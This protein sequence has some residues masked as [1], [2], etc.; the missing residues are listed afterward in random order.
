VQAAALAVGFLLVSLYGGILSDL[1][2]QLF[3][4]FL[5]VSDGRLLTLAL[6]ACAVL[7]LLAVLARPLLLVS[8]DPELAASRGLRV[9]LISAAFL[10][11]LALAVAA[12]SQITGVLLVFALLVG[13]P[14]SAQ[15]LTARPAAGLALSVVLGVLVA[16]I[17]LGLSYFSSYPAGF[18][19][20]TTSTVL[21]LTARAAG[22]LWPRLRP[23]R[24]GLLAAAG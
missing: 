22:A 3:G 23:R 19:I 20:A 14:A 9:R 16:W 7:A 5:G 15:A 10:L 4:T 8:V 6:V 21:Y 24:D 17:G 2:G 1:E 11:A 18:F 12:T 13:P